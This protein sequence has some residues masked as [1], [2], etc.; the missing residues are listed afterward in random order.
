MQRHADALM[1]AVF[2]AAESSFAQLIGPYVVLT[3]VV[4]YEELYVVP[5]CPAGCQFE[6]SAS[7]VLQSFSVLDS[8]AV[9]SEALGSANFQVVAR[10]ALHAVIA[11][12]SCAIWSR[13]TLCTA[14]GV[15]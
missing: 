14:V 12:A 9:L 5:C 4:G 13:N 2:E 3:S 6:E 15:W 11:S 8:A 10:S 1:H 7:A